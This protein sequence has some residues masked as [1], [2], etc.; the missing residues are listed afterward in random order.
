[1]AL[2]PGRLHQPL[3][4]LSLPNNTPCLFEYIYLKG[5]P[6]LQTGS[7]CHLLKIEDKLTNINSTKIKA[8]A[9]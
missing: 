5:S 2:N 9:N 6:I 8:L 3:F 7:Q 4:T 1:M